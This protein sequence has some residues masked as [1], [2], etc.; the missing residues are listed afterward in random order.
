M[1]GAPPGKAQAKPP[2]AR[3]ATPAPKPTLRPRPSPIPARSEKD[4]ALLRHLDAPMLFV[5]RHSY[6]GYH[7]YDT[8]YRSR[9]GGG[10]YILDNPRAD[11]AEH[12]VRP[13]VDP[14]TPASPGAGHY[15]DPELS[16][17]ARRVLFCYQKDNGSP[18]CIY[19]VGIDGQ[20]LRKL[21]DPTRAGGRAATRTVARSTTWARPTCP[22]GG[23]CSP[24][25]APTG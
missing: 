22:T 20:H 6:R 19:E 3:K 4:K 16:W 15:T 1:Q 17:D 12:K 23:S 18:T 24:R 9:P 25:R 8:Y 13:L 10:I 7:I 2:P 14:T 11:P 21:T 5:K